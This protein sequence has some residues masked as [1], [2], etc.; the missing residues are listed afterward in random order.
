VQQLT[1]TYGDGRV[2]VRYLAR[3]RKDGTL[4]RI[5]TFTTQKA[6]EAAYRR[7]LTQLE[8]GNYVEKKA[9]KTPF[10]DVANHWLAPHPGTWAPRTLATNKDIV[11]R[12]LKALHKLPISAV[13]YEVV[14]RTL[15]GWTNDG[16]AHGTRKRSYAVLKAVLADAE[17]RDL[18]SRN[19]CHKVKW[20][21][22]TPPP[23]ARLHIPSPTDV[24]RL[25][26]ATPAPW[27]LLV[28]LAAYSG[29]RAGELAG[30][31]VRH[32]N[33]TARTVRVEQ[34]VADLDGALTLGKPKSHAGYRTVGDLDDDLCQRL[35]VH[36]VGKRSN[37]FVFGGWDDDGKPRPHSHNNFY[38]RQF[39]PTARKLGLSVRFHDLRHYYASLLFD[40]GLTPLE[41]AARLGHHDGAF[42]LRTYGHLFAKDD[43][44]LGKRIADRRAAA[45][46]ASGNV[47]P[48][49]AVAG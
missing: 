1:K 10:L 47:V 16:L 8:S 42:T 40:L 24:E 41:V 38:A 49:R 9:R 15:S 3:V 19:P 14:T 44:G 21:D 28:E 48:L 34:T 26:V 35:A 5:G 18:I 33:T 17:R 43:T 25:I 11:D 36:L 4:T 2:A 39:Q 20:K 12:R 46:K 30:L 32:L 22:E 29:L 37:D 31:Q 7:A 23:E 45:R 27:A 13:T 6:A